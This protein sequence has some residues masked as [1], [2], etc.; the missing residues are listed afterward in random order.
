MTFDRR[1]LLTLPLAAGLTLPAFARN[2]AQLTAGQ[3]RAAELP[4]W[5]PAERF[6]LWPGIPQGAPN[7]LPVPQPRMPR[8]PD[9]YRDFQM[10]GV[11]RPEV[12]VFRP[13]RPDGRAVL[14][15]PGGGY[16]ITSLRNEGIDVARV[17]NTF[18]ITAF[19]LSY[20]LPG[21]G[22]A[23]R[24]DVPLAD[25]QRA[26]RLIRANARSYGIRAEELGVLGFSAGGHLAGSLT[27]LPDFKAYRTVD[28]ADRHSARPAW[29]GL[30]YA[31]SNMD[32]G[33]SHG[34]S[35]ANLLGPDPLPA[36]QA[37]FAIDRQLK[38]GDPPLFLVHAEDDNTVPVANSV[39]TLAAARRAGIPAEAHFLQHGGHGFGTRL[40]PRSPGSLWPQLFDRW[41][42]ELVSG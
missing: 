4:V 23:D 26:M 31:V 37:R 33:R 25:T 12:G 1:S 2:G 38:A 7:P 8:Y 20:R 13:T 24:A 21:E 42:G 15:V 11:V 18:G 34:G 9:G 29:A 28:A 41:M 17:L 6:A 27:I 32:P 10:R 30:M 22:W 14:I 16:S 36:V 3:P 39:D 40:S 19:V 5:P 35:R